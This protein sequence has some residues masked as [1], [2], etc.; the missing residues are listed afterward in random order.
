[1]C[2][3]SYIQEMKYVGSNS[4]TGSDDCVV[5]DQAFFRLPFLSQGRRPDSR[6]HDTTCDSQV[7]Q[8]Q[9]ATRCAQEHVISAHAP[10]RKF[11]GKPVHRKIQVGSEKRRDLVM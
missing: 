10:P 11:V 6:L 4:L 2:W 1:M 9:P 7:T 5:S 3:S 8:P